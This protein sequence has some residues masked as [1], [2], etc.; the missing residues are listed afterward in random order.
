M[1]PSPQ[2][3]RTKVAIVLLAF[4][5]VLGGALLKITVG[6][7]FVFFYSERYTSIGWWAFALLFPVIAVAMFNEQVKVHMRLRY[8]TWWVRWLMMYPLSVALAAAAVVIAPLG[9]IAALT[10]ATGSSAEPTVGRLI[11]VG[12]YRPS[13]KGCDQRGELAMHGKTASICLEGLA[14]L[15][16]RGNVPVVVSGK[17]SNFGLLIEGLKQQ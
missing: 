13:S 11:S 7:R 6:S 8:P 15:P 1:Q 5:L 9:W 4:A 3:S 10:L 12:D 14:V 16:M 17:Q 2:A